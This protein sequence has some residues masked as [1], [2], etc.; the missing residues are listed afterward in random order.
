MIYRLLALAAL[1]ALA[2]GFEAAEE[3]AAPGAKF[4]KD[5]LE[6]ILKREHS[7]RI[8]NIYDSENDIQCAT[9]VRASVRQQP[10]QPTRAAVGRYT[11]NVE[12]QELCPG[13]DGKCSKEEL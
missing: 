11:W 7:D 4:N 1:V 10:S 2:R 8:S 12:A 13:V 6:K 5:E 3:S 9:P